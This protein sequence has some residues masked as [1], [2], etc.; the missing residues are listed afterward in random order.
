MNQG[1]VLHPR[2]AIPDITSTHSCS[3]VNMLQ[4]II[5]P[6]MHSDKPSPGKNNSPK[7]NGSSKKKS[8]FNST[9]SAP[10]TKSSEES[11]EKYIPTDPDEVLQRS[12]AGDGHRNSMAA[13]GRPC[14]AFVTESSSS[15][16]C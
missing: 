13:N 2:P 4:H 3:E 8:L 15:E 16:R 11:H 1:R 14:V 9:K 7:N 5:S 12:I 10:L 6:G